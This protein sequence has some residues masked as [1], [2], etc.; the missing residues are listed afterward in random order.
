MSGIYSKK[1]EEQKEKL[2]AQTREWRK[3]NREK[4]K[5]YRSLYNKTHPEQVK[6]DRTAAR[7][8]RKVHP[9]Y[10]AAWQKNNPQKVL[11]E[12]H[13]YRARISGTGGSFTIQE[14]QTLLAQYNWTCPGCGRK[15]PNIKLTVDHIIPISKGGSGNIENIQPLCKLC[16]CKKYT[17]ITNF[18]P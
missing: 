17:R 4:I 1:T 14:W 12:S 11:V 16:N 3:A 18:Q 7:L 9:E 2:R 15:E 8:W 6:K 5:A 10:M 13:A